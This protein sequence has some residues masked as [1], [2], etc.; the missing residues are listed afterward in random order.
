MKIALPFPKCPNCEANSSSSIHKDCGGKLRIET[1]TD[2]VYCDNCSHHW[3]I[4]DSNYF[5][6]SCGHIFSAE[7]VSHTLTA[8]LVAC[9]VAAEELSAQDS[10][11]QE[12]L[13]CSRSSMRKFFEQFFQQLGY[14]FGVAIGTII[15][16]VLSFMFK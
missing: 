9:R 11:R 13:K 15:A 8:V 10:A 3:N 2:E 4:W 1:S 14:H 6:S 12:R 16:S 7:Q 5:C